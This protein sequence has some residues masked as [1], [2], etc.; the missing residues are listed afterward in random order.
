M[1]RKSTKRTWYT[2]LRHSLQLVYAALIASGIWHAYYWF[3]TI[4]LFLPVLGGNFYCGWLCPFGTVQEWLGKLG[5]KITRKKIR[6][7]RRLHRILSLIRYI[8]FWLM[9]L[10]VWVLY[11]INDPYVTFQAFLSANLAYISV[12]S[13]A[14]LAGFLVL[15]MF[16][17]RP[18]CTLLCTEGAQY[19]M[20]G[21]FRIFTIKRDSKKCVDCGACDRV[22]PSRVNVSGYSQVRSAQCM[23]CFKCISVCRR[24][25]ALRFGPALPNIRELFTR[26]N[27]EKA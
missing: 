17:D 19:G 3:V 9:F 14:V 23:N 2:I 8:L 18:F 26:R 22:C 12:I 13:I 1:N 25:R 24:H 5:S 11:I 4:L 20:A 15:S 7:P 27:H 16:M 6:L 10:G 21:M